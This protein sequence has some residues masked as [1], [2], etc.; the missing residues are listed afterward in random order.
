MI[1][2]KKKEIETI[3]KQK[4]AHSSVD[5]TSTDPEKSDENGNPIKLVRF[6]E[7]NLGDLCTDAIRKRTNADVVF[8]NGGGVRSSIKKGD[9][10]YGDIVSVLP[11]NNI[12]CVIE[13]SGQQILDALEWGSSHTPEES[14]SFLQVSGITYDIDTSINSPCVANDNGILLS[15][16]GPRRVSNVLINGEPI[17]PDKIYTVAGTD[18][19]LL[20]QG[21]GNTAFDA[22]KVFQKIS[23]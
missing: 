21:G 9:I 18:H 19:V 23:V 2:E 12:V 20:N 16:S 11:F 6:S 13:A 1:E 17:N 14:G 8:Q 4:V 10:T 22:S 7:T 3:L 15:I 5:L